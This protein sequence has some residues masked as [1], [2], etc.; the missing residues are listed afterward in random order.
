MGIRMS[1]M[2]LEV[3]ANALGGVHALTL[4]A[5]RPRHYYHLRGQTRQDR[6]HPL[7]SPT[8][9]SVKI[10]KL[11]KLPLGAFKTYLDRGAFLPRGKGPMIR[12][13][14]RSSSRRSFATSKK[15]S[16]SRWLDALRNSTLRYPQRFNSKYRTSSAGPL[17][18]ESTRVPQGCVPQ[19]PL[20]IGGQPAGGSPAP[21]LN[22]VQG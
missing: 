7:L 22:V 13:V 21:D 4:F 11:F 19:D 5:A 12:R 15:V 10:I 8:P 17:E 18:Q 3:R 14:W 16:G 20:G 9:I 1:T 2:D 6:S